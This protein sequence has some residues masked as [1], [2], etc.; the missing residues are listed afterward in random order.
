MAYLNVIVV[1]NSPFEAGDVISWRDENLLS[2]SGHYGIGTK[3]LQDERFKIVHIPDMTTAEANLLCRQ[4]A[5]YNSTK[6]RATGEI[7]PANP[8]AK[9]RAH[10]FNVNLLLAQDRTNIT[11]ANKSKEQRFVM[12]PDGMPE[13]LD[14][15][16]LEITLDRF[17]A[18]SELKPYIDNRPDAIPREIK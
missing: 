2:E 10:K 12:K 14:V 18:A 1:D 11:K 15:T 9:I 4:Q 6:N 3:T 13:M 8:D 17:N 7:I 5:G 16:N